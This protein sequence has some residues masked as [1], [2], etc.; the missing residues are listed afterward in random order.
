MNI[1]AGIGSTTILLLAI[2]VIMSIYQ[3]ISFLNCSI[4][5]LQLDV[6]KLK[7]QQK[8]KKK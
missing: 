3:Y 7:N 4:L 6:N 5:D 2:L 8:G 1:L